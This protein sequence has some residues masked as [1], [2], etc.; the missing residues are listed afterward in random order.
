SG[1]YACWSRADEPRRPP[2]GD[3]NHEGKRGTRDLTPALNLFLFFQ[4]RS[5]TLELGLHEHFHLLCFAHGEQAFLR[6][7]PCAD[8][9]SAVTAAVNNR[10]AI[11]TTVRLRLHADAAE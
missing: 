8:A 11:R 2:T 5:V 7:H 6:Q 3:M 1:N 10:I 9:T 4:P